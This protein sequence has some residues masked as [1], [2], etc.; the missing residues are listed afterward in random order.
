MIYQLTSYF[1]MFLAIFDARFMISQVADRFSCDCD[2]WKVKR[3]ILDL[4]V[5]AYVFEKNRNFPSRSVRVKDER[6]V[7]AEIGGTGALRIVVGD[8]VASGESNAGGDR[9]TPGRLDKQRV[10]AGRRI[11][12]NDVGNR[13][14]G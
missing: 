7:D 13:G 12:I 3:Y 8:A 4:R 10:H 6:F 11:K 5:F 9:G 1:L 14:D 2:A